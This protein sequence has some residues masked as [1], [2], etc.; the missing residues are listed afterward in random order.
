MFQLVTPQRAVVA[1]GPAVEHA[2]VRRHLHR[3]VSVRC[4]L[5][6]QAGELTSLTVTVVRTCPTPT[7]AASAVCLRRLTTLARYTARRQRRRPEM[8]ARRRR[9]ES[10]FASPP[11]QRRCLL[12]V[13]MFRHRTE[14]LSMT[15]RRSCIQLHVAES[16]QPPQLKHTTR[17]HCQLCQSRG[18]G[19]R[20]KMQ[21]QQMH[22]VPRGVSKHYIGPVGGQFSKKMPPSWVVG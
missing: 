3:T 15:L 10:A 18:G 19:G 5:T 4:L 1:C 22:L 8:F 11:R 21:D 2:S 7:L 20:L 16:H 12:S 6:S 14:R 17:S 9:C 13:R